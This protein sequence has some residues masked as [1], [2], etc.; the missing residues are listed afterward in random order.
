MNVTDVLKDVSRRPDLGEVATEAKV[1]LR[2]VEYLGRDPLTALRD[3]SRSTPSEKFSNFLGVLISIIETGGDV[4]S[5]FKSRTSEYHDLMEEQLEEKV[6]T[7]EFMAEIYV[8]LVS[9]APLLFLTLLIFLGYLQ[10]VSD[11]VLMIIAYVWIPLGSIAFAVLIATRSREK[12]G[13]NPPKFSPP[14][15]YS[16]VPTTEGNESDSRIIKQIRKTRG[17]DKLKRILS[18]PFKAITHQPAFTL[19][20][21]APLA[22]YLGLSRWTR[23]FQRRKPL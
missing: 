4:T 18:S 5:Y 21:S 22:R 9:F 6:T 20:F 1:F 11:M 23:V 15:P 13:G 7:L 17:K 19:A 12:I 2:D 14:Q 16:S 8:I 3:L 10:P